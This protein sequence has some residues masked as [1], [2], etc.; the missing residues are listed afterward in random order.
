[1]MELNETNNSELESARKKLAQA[2]KENDQAKI[3]EISK[4]IKE[5]TDEP[6]YENC[7]NYR[8]PKNTLDSSDNSFNNDFSRNLTQST[9]SHSTPLTKP[10]FTLR[11]AAFIKQDLR[12]NLSGTKEN[13]KDRNIIILNDTKIEKSRLET[14][15]ENLDEEE[16]VVD[17]LTKSELFKSFC[18]LEVEPQEENVI[19]KYLNKLV[20]IAKIPLSLVTGSNGEIQEGEHKTT[21]HE[22]EYKTIEHEPEHEEIENKQT[23]HKLKNPFANENPSSSKATSIG[24]NFFWDPEGTHA[25]SLTTL[26]KL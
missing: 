20:N 4:Q 9:Q 3:L 5:L 1:M 11:K 10:R 26:K 23:V 19:A 16:L 17:N 15:I 18:N 24:D 12:N 7:Q 13:S 6:I 2:Y 25:T 14:I 21:E 22:P 8:D